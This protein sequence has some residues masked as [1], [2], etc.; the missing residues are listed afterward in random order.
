MIRKYVG[1]EDLVSI[2]HGLS[3]MTTADIS[4][5]LLMEVALDVDNTPLDDDNDN[6]GTATVTRS[7]RA[8]ERFL[9]DFPL[10]RIVVVIDTH[11]P[12]SGF[13]LWTEDSKGN[14]ETTPLLPVS[15]MNALSPS[16]PRL[17]P[18][19]I[20]K[21]CIPSGIFKFLSNATDTPKHSHRAIILNLSCGASIIKD[22]SRHSL[23]E[24][25]VL[26]LNGCC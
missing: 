3:P 21:D 13:F 15:T 16:F 8:A 4:Q 23:L 10:A 12:E 18:H 17:T 2:Q 19:Q 1:N 22:E 24:G 26:D 25:W 5:L 20:L 9:A 11:C 6:N 14:F 7:S